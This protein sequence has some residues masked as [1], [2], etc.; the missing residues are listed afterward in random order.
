MG[1]CS[2]V[3]RPRVERPRVIAGRAP[4]LRTRPPMP[5]APHVVR[6]HDVRLSLLYKGLLHMCVNGTELFAAYGYDMCL[7]VCF[8]YCMKRSGF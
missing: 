2:G 4:T 8:S 3:E 6:L 1:C 7:C 5:S